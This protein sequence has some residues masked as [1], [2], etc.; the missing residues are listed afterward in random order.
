MDRTNSM[1]LWTYANYYLEAV[2]VMPPTLRDKPPAYY[3]VT[4]SIELAIKA[5]LRGNS[6]SLEQLKKIGHDIE[7][8]MKRANTLG[9]LSYCNLSRTQTELIKLINQHYASKELEY[10]KT[11]FKQYPK[12]DLLIEIAE[13][14]LSGIRQFCYDHRTDTEDVP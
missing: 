10:I 3:L 4:H 6:M 8:A 2:K 14:L 1:G 13:L 7:K 12:I 5:F 11:G 9:L